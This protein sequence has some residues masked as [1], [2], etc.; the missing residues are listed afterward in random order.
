VHR[1]PKTEQTSLKARVLLSVTSFMQKFVYQDS[2]R[3]SRTVG[4]PP[5]IAATRLE[6]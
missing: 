2:S 4:Q 6:M 5:A 1:P 3:E